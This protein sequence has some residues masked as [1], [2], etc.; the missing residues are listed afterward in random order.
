[1]LF[2]VFIRRFHRS[3][4]GGDLNI[5]SL[6][7]Q[8][9]ALPL[10][11]THAKVVPPRQRDT[12][13]GVTLWMMRTHLRKSEQWFTNTQTPTH[14]HTH[15]LTA[16]WQGASIHVLFTSSTQILTTTAQKVY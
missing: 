9:G 1:M 11:Y 13:T 3:G 16:A 15:T 6:D 14:T 8:S 2:N 7:L 12:Q 5:G 10:G 4:T